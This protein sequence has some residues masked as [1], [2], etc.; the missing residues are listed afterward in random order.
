M[1]QSKV[2]SI[3]S[4]LNFDSCRL[5]FFRQHYV[6]RKYTQE[7]LPSEEEVTGYG[8]DISHGPLFYLGMGYWEHGGKTSVTTTYNQN[9]L[10]SVLLTSPT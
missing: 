7:A 2:S 1:L 3:F 9:L 5:H 10:Q 4:F 6:I 8:M